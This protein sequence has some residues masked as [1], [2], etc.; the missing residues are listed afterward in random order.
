MNSFIV[1]NIFT[2]VTLFHPFT[3]SNS[4]NKNSWAAYQVKGGKD[5]LANMITAGSVLCRSSQ[6]DGKLTW[7]H[8]RKRG[9]ESY[10]QEAMETWF[11]PTLPVLLGMLHD[12]FYF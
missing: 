1:I 10:D 8:R 2:W 7:R 12:L 3:V 4:L 5:I 9:G 6:S 11:E